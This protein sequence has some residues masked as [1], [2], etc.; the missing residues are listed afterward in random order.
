M[1][2][3][4]IDPWAAKHDHQKVDLVFIVDCTGS[5]GSYIKQTQKNIRNIAEQISKTAFNVRLSLVEYR[6]HPPQDRSFVTR[7][8]DFTHSVDEMKSWVDGMSASGGGDGPESVA[9]AL[10][11]ATELNYRKDATKMCILIADAPPHGL[12]QQGD[13]F[14]SGCPEGFDPLVS[15]RKMAEKGITL[16]FVGCEPSVLPYKDF[17]TGLAFI[18]GGQYVPLQ[19]PDALSKVVINGALEEV[20]LEKLMGYVDDFI[21][22]EVIQKRQK[23]RKEE[24]K[25]VNVDDLAAELHNRLKITKTQC[26]QLQLD[27][28]TLEGASNMAKKVSAKQNIDEARMLL[29]NQMSRQ[30]DYPR[31]SRTPSF[32]TAQY[33]FVSKDQSERL[34]RKGLAR[35]KTPVT[36]DEEKDAIIVSDTVPD[37][38]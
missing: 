8:H 28:N 25:S 34:V 2:R 1:E 29:K 33:Q 35:S 30:W 13:G 5:M 31:T 23:A 4:F 22:L 18:T 14:P 37:E 26:H 11:K 16:Y 15:C 38:V 17:Y 20:S 3:G 6:D 19:N 24:R 27:E 21:Q 36:H 32:T 10:E 9:D 7:V 12:D